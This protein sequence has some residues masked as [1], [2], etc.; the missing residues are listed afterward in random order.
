MKRLNEEDAAIMLVL[1]A[2][3]VVCGLITIWGLFCSFQG[4]LPAVIWTALSATATCMLGEEV[5]R[6]YEDAKNR[7]NQ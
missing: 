3:A 2:F 5:R 1:G 6:I 7:S 4:N